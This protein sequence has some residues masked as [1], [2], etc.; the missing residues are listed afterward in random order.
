MDIA[1]QFVYDFLMEMN[2]EQ[3]FQQGISAHK[4]GRFQEA[5]RLYRAI[6]HSQPNHPD[7][8]HNLGLLAVV[9]GQVDVALPYFKAALDANPKQGQFWFSYIDALIKLDQ[10]DAA[11]QA[12]MQGKDAGLTGDKLDH[13][14]ALL[15]AKGGTASSLQEQ[16]SGLFRLYKQGQLQLAIVKGQALAN[17]FPKEPNI[18]N[19]LG[20]MN[21]GLGKYEE[22]IACFN[23]AV[24]LK[25]DYAEVYYN[26]ALARENLKQ[27]E[28]AVANYNKAIALKH[29][30]A[31]AHTNLG[32]VLNKLGK[33]E[34]AIASHNKA[35]ELNPGAAEAY[36]NRGVALNTLRRHEEAIASHNKAIELNPGA[37]EAYN[38][39]GVALLDN[40]KHEA[41]VASYNKAIELKP[42][43]AGA[44]DNLSTLLVQMGIQ[45]YNENSFINKAE[46]SLGKNVGLKFLCAKMVKYFIEGNIE[47]AKKAQL[48][49]DV[50]LRGDGFDKLCANDKI[51]CRAYNTIIKVL[52][53]IEYEVNHLIRHPKVFHIGESHCLSFAHQII[54]I[55]GEVHTIQPRIIFGAKAWHFAKH[56]SNQYK[57]LLKNHIQ[58]IPNKSNVF[59]SFGEIDCRQD[60][61]ILHF[62]KNSNKSLEE[63]IF[64]TVNGYTKFI[65]DQFR[66]KNCNLFFFGVPAPVI[67]D[68]NK[69]S[70]SDP[71]I[72]RITTIQKYNEIL[73]E[74]VNAA[75]FRFIDSYSF[76]SDEL[77]VSNKYYHMDGHH[78][79]PAAITKI[80]DLLRNI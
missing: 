37:A 50:G 39:L 17:Q 22:A 1:K 57:S 9:V 21:F 45:S 28:E 5:E 41:A 72:D 42:D 62:R 53:N 7:A 33:Y 23:K 70:M 48:E 26:L 59:L 74:R 52:I 11:R 18:P 10:I 60:E 24:E 43:Y 3:A 8:N 66:D 54:Q 6:L 4:E 68:F 77:G 15:D 51:F 38:N 78:L 14:I 29:D 25:P 30:Y 40:G 35:I 76:T 36:T 75:H 13:L 79:G 47:A 19:I 32:N 55:N 34:E 20:V 56:G 64:A 44:L 80:K 65:I 61:G 46:V 12:L 67:P 69:S 73:K 27:H 49:V 63:I 16:M 2:I 58:S 31:Q 71:S